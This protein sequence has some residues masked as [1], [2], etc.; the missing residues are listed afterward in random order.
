MNKSRKGTSFGFALVN[1]FI[2][3][4]VLIV[5]LA[6]FKFSVISVFLI[7]IFS[8]VLLAK[9]NGFTLSEIQEYLICGTKKSVL[10]ILI[11][12]IFFAPFSSLLFA[13]S[14]C[15]SGSPELF[16][17]TSFSSGCSV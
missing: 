15:F 4:V 3:A 9:F 14:G 10:I 6:Y 16:C 13:A 8:I 7:A 17:T 5:G 2:L 1:I 12:A 11:L